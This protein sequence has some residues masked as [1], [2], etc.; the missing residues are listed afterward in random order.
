MFS[1]PI[2]NWLSMRRFWWRV[3][4]VFP[5][6]RWLSCQEFCQGWPYLPG[7]TLWRGRCWCRSGE[8]F[9]ISSRPLSYGVGWTSFCECWRQPWN[10]LVAFRRQEIAIERVELI[11]DRILKDLSNVTLHRYRSDVLQPYLARA[12]FRKDDELRSF[13]VYWSRS[14]HWC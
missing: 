5:L 2:N 7:H 12:R 4:Y 10:L 6:R 9:C 14:G 8:N 13:E 11:L 1:E 3:R